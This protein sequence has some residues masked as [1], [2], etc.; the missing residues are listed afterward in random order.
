[1]NRSGRIFAAAA[2]ALGLAF[3]PGARAADEMSLGRPGA[4][5]RVIE[6][7]SLGCPHCGVWSR[8]VFPAFRRRYIDT[9]KVRFVLREML[10]GDANVAAAGFLT[11]RC[12]GRGKY[13]QVVDGLF[14]AQPQIERDGDDLPSLL[15]VAAAAGLGQP[16]VSACLA[17]KAALAALEARADAYV[18]DDHVT[19]TPSFDIAGKRIVGEA[20]LADVSAAVDAA[21]AQARGR[22]R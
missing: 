11:A 8:E 1:V 7:A 10:F 16:Q 15:K 5:V 12:A 4:P 6:Y 21:L 2:M 20:S 19:A 22:R 17:D 3:A 14:A 18:R 9:G 13:F